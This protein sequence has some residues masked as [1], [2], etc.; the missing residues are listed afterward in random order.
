MARLGK[1]MSALYLLRHAKAEA[2]NPGG[3]RDRV[4]AERGRA[5]A[6]AMAAIVAKRAIAPELVLCSGAAR[7]RETLAILLPMLNPAPRVLTEDEIYLADARQLLK[8][9]RAVPE[10][11][12]SLMLVGHNP[13]LQE[14][15]LLLSDRNSG[16]PMTK[17]AEGFPTSALACF[18]ALLPWPALEPRSATLTAMLTAP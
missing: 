2:K 18:E 12:E 4:L 17:L 15:A 11:V 1:S 9:L 16:P 14:L 5:D 13:G 10:A 6:K 7:T 8:R 3:D